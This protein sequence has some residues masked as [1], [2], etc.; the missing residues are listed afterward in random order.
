[1]ARYWYSNL[2]QNEYSKWHR[3]Y[4]GI[5]MID[6]D[7]IEVCP[8]CYEPLAIKETCKEMGQKYKATTLVKT[9]SDRLR[10]PSFLVFYKKV[11]QGS[12]AFRIKRLHVPNADYEYMNE[13]EWVREL[14]QLQEDHKDCCKY[15]TPHNI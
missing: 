2:K 4:E 1:M 6:V 5:A 11:G 14:Y 9:L 12:L 10:V 8:Q 13:D 15:A 3:Q 7:G